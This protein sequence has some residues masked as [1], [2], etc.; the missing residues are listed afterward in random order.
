MLAAVGDTSTVILDGPAVVVIVSV[1]DPDFVGS[2]C[3]VA[4]IDTCAGAGT[5]AGAVYK[6]ALEIVPFAAPPT[7]VQVTAVLKVSSTVAVICCV[8]PTTIF[9][10]VGVTLTETIFPAVPL[11]HPAKTNTATNESSE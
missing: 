7:T 4:V 5:V 9:T 6:P 11:L 3:D 2:L 10:P 1:A 8:V